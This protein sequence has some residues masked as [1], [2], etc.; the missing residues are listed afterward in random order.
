MK[1]TIIISL[2]CLIWF[3]GICQ[4]NTL[5]LYKL[6]N[7]KKA[8]NIQVDRN[9]K[10]GIQKEIDST[11]E[12]TWINGKLNYVINDTLIISVMDYSVSKNHTAASKT[13]NEHSFYYK[14]KSA[15]Y[16]KIDHLA[17]EDISIIQ[18]KY[19]KNFSNWNLVIIFLPLFN[20]FVVAPLVSMDYSDWKINT[21][22]YKKFGMAST[23]VLFAGI[24]TAIIYN[25]S[26]KKF[27]LKPEWPKKE[28]KLWTYE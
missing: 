22:T 1:R 4:N 8:K 26:E 7:K 11:K 20:S 15:E 28:A 3:S 6:P 2:L 5:I 27:Q 17:L 13:W 18:K 14:K 25:L 16:I 24:S 10:V 23:Y 21:D 19:N 12:T 9:I